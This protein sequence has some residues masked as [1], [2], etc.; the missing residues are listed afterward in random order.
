MRRTFLEDLRPSLPHLD[1]RE[2]YEILQQGWLAPGL[3]E[4]SRWSLA[5]GGTERTEGGRS[6]I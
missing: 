1:E 6:E 4:C 2:L 5:H 3:A